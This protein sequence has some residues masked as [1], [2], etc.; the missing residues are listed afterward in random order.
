MTNMEILLKKIKQS[1]AKRIYL[2]AVDIE[3]RI[4]TK[5]VT[6][7]QL[8]KNSDLIFKLPDQILSRNFLHGNSKSNDAY[9]KLDPSTLRKCPWDLANLLLMGDIF[10]NDKKKLKIS[11]FCPRQLL[12]KAISSLDKKGYYIK[13]GFEVEW[14][15][16][17]KTIVHGVEAAVL[18]EE[19]SAYSPVT[20][21]KHQKYWSE[22]LDAA[23]DSNLIIEAAHAESGAGANE[24]SLHYS[25]PLEAADNM[26]LLRH[27]IEKKSKDFGLVAAFMAKLGHTLPGSGLH[28]HQSLWRK[29]DKK[30][31]GNSSLFDN[32]LAGQLLY[33]QDIFPLYAPNINSYK[34]Y[35]ADQMSP[36]KINFG[37]D[38]RSCAFRIINS[39]S[40]ARIENRLAGADANPYLVIAASVGCGLLGLEKKQLLNSSAL[41]KL[42]IPRTLNDSIKIFY[43]SKN[44]K[45]ILNES[46]IDSIASRKL[47]QWNE[48]LSVV[49]GWEIKK[50]INYL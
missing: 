35:N 21:K 38:D 48:Y 6:R 29:K 4:K 22:L 40:T 9:I 18:L 45:N 31:L 50:G 46:L 33:A 14:Y 19:Q 47:Q 44:A 41:E 7:V 2:C 11:P 39:K 17:Q 26:I 30:D 42:D 49:T 15:N 43:Q 10:F 36:K 20:F 27:L 8:L 23:Q 25:S 37:V 3:G 24:I 16:V 5:V 32:F 1:S 28:L 13:C 34:R 12:K